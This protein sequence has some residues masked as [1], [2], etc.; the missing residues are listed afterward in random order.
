MSTGVFHARLSLVVTAIESSRRLGAI[1]LLTCGY[2]SGRI[3]AGP[4]KAD[5]R[6]AAIKPVNLQP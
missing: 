4:K 1:A 3:S 5:E 2:C 6:I